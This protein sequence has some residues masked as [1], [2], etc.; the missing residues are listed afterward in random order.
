[1]RLDQLTFQTLGNLSCTVAI[2]QGQTLPIAICLLGPTIRYTVYALLAPVS[3]PYSSIVLM[4][5]PLYQVQPL[6]KAPVNMY[7]R[8][9]SIFSSASCTAVCY[10]GLKSTAPREEA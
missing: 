3:G 9:E 7:I 10:H 5:N 1:M 4:T 8:Y 6:T 2:S